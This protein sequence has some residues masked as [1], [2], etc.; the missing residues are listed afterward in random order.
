[1]SPRTKKILMIVG[2]LV[3]AGL[4][5]FGLYTMFKRVT[6]DGALK[7]G[8][9][10]TTTPG[11]LP[12]AGEREPGTTT[13]SGTE[14]GEQQLPTAGYIPQVA[15]SYYKPTPVNKVTSDYATFT[16]MDNAGALRYYNAADGKFYHVLSNGQIQEMSDEIFYNVKKVTWANSADKAVLEYPDKAKIIYNFDTKKQVSIPSHWEEFSF[17]PDSS[18]LAAKSI[19]LSPEN[20]WLIVFNDDGTGTKLIEPMGNNADKV[21]IDWSPSRQVVAFSRTGEPLGLERKEILF[22]GLNG[23]NFKSAIVEG[24]DFRSQWSPTG[25]RLLYSVYSSRTS[26]KPELWVVDS[27][28]DSIGSNRQTL[29]LNTWAE[30]CAFQNDTTLYC[31]VPKN[32]PD[33]AGMLPELAAGAYDDLY[34]I[35]L[36]T[37]LK[38]SVPLGGDYEIG[39]ISFDA[40]NEKV[41]FTDKNQ[42]GVFEVKLK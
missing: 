38:T 31:A 10:A 35:D 28:G 39:Q 19:G 15:P 22:V 11:K 24:Q 5:A 13:T 14:P 12:S 37:G 4:I 18:E 41:F 16:S 23:E 6:P 36:T 33:G 27:Y 3:V 8:Q 42:S 30:K 17:S 29:K 34:K 32:L 9:V 1:M 40:N 25:Q 2:L 26:Y 21:T 7:P 20:R